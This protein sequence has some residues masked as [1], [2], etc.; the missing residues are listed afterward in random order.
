ML[1]A[2]SGAGGLLKFAPTQHPQRPLPEGR[3]D[4]TAVIAEIDAPVD[5]IKC[6]SQ[7][8]ASD[9]RCRSPPLKVTFPVTSTRP[10]HTKPPPMT[11]SPSTNRMPYPVPFWIF[12]PSALTGFAVSE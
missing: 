1:G 10:F 7:D 9:I 12:N 6:A 8:S 3:F 11:R 5:T 4:L 2:S